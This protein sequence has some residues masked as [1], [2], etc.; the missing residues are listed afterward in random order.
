M[1]SVSKY[2]A[3]STLSRNTTIKLMTSEL[4][5]ADHLKVLQLL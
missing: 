2:H 1:K 5:I 3:V 4:I